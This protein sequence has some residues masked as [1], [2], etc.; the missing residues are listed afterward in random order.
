MKKTAF[1]IRLL[2]ILITASISAQAQKILTGPLP[3][4]AP[5]QNVLASLSSLPEADALLYFNPQR[6]LNEAAPR[7]MAEK[8]LAEMRKSFEELK[9]NVGVDPAKVEYLVIATRFRKPAADLSFAP[10]EFLVVAGGDFSADSL[11]TLAK[12]AAGE[13]LR[14]E[15]YGSKTLGVMTIDPIVKEAEKNPILRAYSEIGI[16]GL[17]QTTIAVG[18]IPYLKAAIDAGAGNGRITTANLNSLLRDPTVLISAAGSPWSSFS[19]SFGLRGTEAN[20]RAPRCDTQLGDF[21]ASVT[22]DS[23]NFL[24]RGSMNADNPDTAKIFTNLISGLM[25]QAS[26]IPDVSVQSALKSVSITAD[27]N[28]VVVRADVPQQVVL[29]FIKKQS[30]QKKPEPAADKPVTPVK[31]Q[32]VR[33]KRK[34]A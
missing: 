28:D 10:P 11:L 23:T 18:S 8:D 9:K 32:P 4:N 15:K 33:R 31:K 16:V 27:E 1:L 24:L 12:L 34:R 17:N 20:A 29:D 21:Y 3:G 2:S 6:I 5:N 26:S 22:M 19:K 14:D 30:M 7:L 25:R 13:K